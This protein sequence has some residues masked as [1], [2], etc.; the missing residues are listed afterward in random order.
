MG[1]NFPIFS[2]FSTSTEKFENRSGI[3]SAEMFGQLFEIA[4][5]NPGGGDKISP[6]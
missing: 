1:S 5:V 2:Q 3:V 6:Y 4:K